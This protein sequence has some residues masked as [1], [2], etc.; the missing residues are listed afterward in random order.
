MDWKRAFPLFTL[1]VG[2]IVGVFITLFVLSISQPRSKLVVKYNIIPSE[3]SR[4]NI[5]VN[6]G[7][8]LDMMKVFMDDLRSILNGMRI[9]MYREK[10]VIEWSNK[11]LNRLREAGISPQKL[12]QLWR[13]KRNTRKSYD[14]ILERFP[15]IQQKKIMEIF[16]DVVE[17]EDK[18]IYFRM[19]SNAVTKM[20]E[21]VKKFTF[22]YRIKYEVRNIGSE[23][24][25]HVVIKIDPG[26]TIFFAETP[27]SEDEIQRFEKM[28]NIALI[29]LNSLS[30]NSSVEGSVWCVTVKNKIPI[31]A[32]FEGG[33]A[34]I[35]GTS[36]FAQGALWYNTIV[37]FLTPILIVII[38]VLSVIIIIFYKKQPGKIPH[39]SKK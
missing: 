20:R 35:K 33:K 1:I 3:Y 15:L 28:S 32:S 6:R 11:H 9:D 26:D 18:E 21:I 29:E 23:K 39:K 17:E 8:A 37:P 25:S 36:S 14:E 19:V 5:K 31:T 27:R 22:G 12:L 30:P 10:T 4:D 34:E 13:E 2:I 38:A 16:R 7:D 24:A